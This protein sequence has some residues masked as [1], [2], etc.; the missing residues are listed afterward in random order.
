MLAA[1]ELHLF[2]IADIPVRVSIWYGLLLLYWFQGGG[3]ARGTLIW[4]I[5]V[6]LSILVHEFGHAIVARAY[7]L[8]PS[9][10]LHG[11]GGLC[12]HD[13]A[14][15]DIHDVFIVAAGPGAGLILGG[16]TWLVSIYAPLA[17]KMNPWFYSV[18]SMSLYINIGWSLVNLLPIWPLD[19]GQ[20]YRLLLLRIFQPARAEKVTHYTALVLLGAAVAV[21]QVT[22]GSILVMLVIWIAFSN[23]SALRGSATSGPVHTVNKGAKQLLMEA[24]QAYAQDDFREA[25]RLGH[26]LRLEHNVADGVAKEGLLVLGLSCARI[27]DHSEALTFLRAQAQTPEVVE[28]RIECLYALGRDDELDKL[29]TSEAFQKLP[30]ARQ[31]E[32]LEIVRPQSNPT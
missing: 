12:N 30:A 17:W 18:V 15:R 9:I 19:G 21:G 31:K 23:V 20:L 24:K 29:L 22:R 14:E 11:L 8:R 16:I 7:R 4:V 26:L 25:A 32:I 10:L 2:D 6:T 28:A 3:N 13:R 27:G 1:M 5:V